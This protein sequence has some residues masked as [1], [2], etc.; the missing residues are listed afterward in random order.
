[1]KDKNHRH[2]HLPK[3]SSRYAHTT[4]A[5]RDFFILQKFSLK[6][7]NL[8]I[9]EVLTFYQS[10]ININICAIKVMALITRKEGRFD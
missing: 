8:E 9:K 7:L 6:N 4:S 5:S 2:K 1:V 10:F 3:T